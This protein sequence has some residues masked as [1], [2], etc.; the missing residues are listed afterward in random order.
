MASKPLVWVY[1]AVGG[2]RWR[3]TVC[4]FVNDDMFLFIP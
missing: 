2:A 4:I 3:S 1:G